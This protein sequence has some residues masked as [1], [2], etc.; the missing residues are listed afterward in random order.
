MTTGPG[1]PL[2]IDDPIRPR[3]SRLVV[4]LGALTIPLAGCDTTTAIRGAEVAAYVAR[5]SVDGVTGTVFQGTPPTSGAG[6][7]VTAP[8]SNAVITGG[9]VQVEVAASSAFQTVAVYVDGSE[10]YHLVTLPTGVTTATLVVTVGS[11]LPSLDFEYRVAVAGA[12]GVFGPAHAT[13]IHATEVISGDIQVSV[14]WNTLADVDL[15]V[16]APTG[17]ELYF[18]NRSTPSG[19]LLD[20]DAN[21]ACVTSP[22]FQENIGWKRG[23]APSG[24]YT[25]R[26]EYWD[27]CGAALTEYVVTVSLRPGVP[28]TP[29]TPGSRIA[30]F[31]GSFTGPGT[32]C[33]AG[34]GQTIT[35]FIF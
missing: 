15:H 28:V 3:A 17:E 19:G 33:G 14:T 10:G 18:G 23:E 21:A 29:I 9:S 31:S 35:T 16:V 12:D 5:V 22:I 30:T 11:L 27:A 13:S 2:T 8:V 34:S 25:V 4:L 32:Q 20:L 24:Q 26:V 1:G 6:P 7:T